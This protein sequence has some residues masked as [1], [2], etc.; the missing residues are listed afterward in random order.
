MY[1]VSNLSN[2]STTDEK[3]NFMHIYMFIIRK[4]KTKVKRFTKG[5]KK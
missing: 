2:A 5:N 4:I 3:L 1:F